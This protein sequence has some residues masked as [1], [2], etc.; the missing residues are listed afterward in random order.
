MSGLS[1]YPVMECGHRA[2]GTLK[3]GVRRPVCAIC[4]GIKPGADVVADPQPVEPKGY[5]CPH[6]RKVSEKP[7]AFSTVT[8]DKD[9]YGSHYD[10]CLG[11]D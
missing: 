10:G 5:R 8:P 2:N 3:D 4:F 11:W 6:C 1:L 9:G 7:M